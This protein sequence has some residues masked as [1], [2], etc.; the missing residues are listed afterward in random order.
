MLAAQPSRRDLLLGAAALAAAGVGGSDRPAARAASPQEEGSPPA[1]RL[2]GNPIAVSTYSY[3]RFRDDTKLAITDCVDLA[4]DAGFDAVEVL[5][6]QMRDTSN[7][8]LQAIKQRAFRHGMSLCGLSTHQ[9]FLSPD[10]AERQK[11]VDHT[12]ECLELAYAMGIPTM[13]VT[14]AGG[15]PRSP[16]TT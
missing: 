12:I 13:R 8:A 2:R 7:A 3:W 5:H 16:S 1:G 10:P 15:A 11:N 9:S 4:A 6:I 14:P